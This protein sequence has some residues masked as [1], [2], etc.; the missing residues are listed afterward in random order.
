VPLKARRGSELRASIDPDGIFGDP[1]SVVRGTEGDDRSDI[2]RLAG[3]WQQLLDEVAVTGDGVPVACVAT[4]AAVNETV[5]FERL[6]QAAWAILAHIGTVFAEG[7]R[8]QAPA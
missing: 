5:V 3:T 2:I 8:C 6:F 1:A 4:A 7:I